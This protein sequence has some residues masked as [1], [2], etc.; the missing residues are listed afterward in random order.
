MAWRARILDV[1]ELFPE[2]F[3]SINPLT[4]GTGHLNH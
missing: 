2:L 1:G 4:D 3:S